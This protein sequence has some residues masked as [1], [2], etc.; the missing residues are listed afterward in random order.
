MLTI[1]VDAM[2]GDNAP[3]SEVEGAVRAARSLGV[4]VILVGQQEVVRRELQQHDGYEELPI[5]I[6]HAS[7][8]VTM[9]DSAARAVRTKRDSSL[10]V[11]SRL[12][13]DGAAEGFVSAGNTGAVM[14]TAKMVQGVV[15]GV[16]RP[17]LAKSLP[18]V[19]SSPVVLVDVGANVDCSPRMLAQF[20]VMGEI[21]S[22]IILRQPK[23]RVGILSIG[24][25]EHKGNELTRSATPLLKSLNLNFIGNVE[26]RD[27]Y[28]GSVDV[29]VCDGFV[30]NVA[31]KVSEGLVEMVKHLLQ[32]SLEATITRKIGYVL[33]RTAFTDFKK[34]VDYSEYG[35]AP[36]LGVRGVCIICHGRSNANAIKNAIRVAAEF[37]HGRVNQRIE[38]ELR[39]AAA[40]KMVIKAN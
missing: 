21:Y 31:L 38:E 23:P 37:S 2:G 26:G 25:E 17:A 22:R 6:V 12:V 11:A 34:R 29:I 13:R 27:I 30:G 35:G 8:R 24:E 18:T 16:D 4:K 3:K 5:E 10:R 7:E 14:A 33:S 39:Q 15:P 40:D 36:L 28:T 32:E 1:A 19:N 9:D 20:A